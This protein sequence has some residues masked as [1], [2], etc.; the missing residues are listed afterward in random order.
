MNKRQ[1]TSNECSV[2]QTACKTMFTRMTRVDHELLI[3][4]VHPIFLY[5][6][7]DWSQGYKSQCLPQWQDWFCDR[8]CEYISISSTQSATNRILKA[9][10]IDGISIFGWNYELKQQEQCQISYKIH[11]WISMLH[12]NLSV[13]SR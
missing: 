8:L 10:L 1:S 7:L 4:F 11:S 12:Q 9:I 5:F 3:F 13:S 6:N 2:R